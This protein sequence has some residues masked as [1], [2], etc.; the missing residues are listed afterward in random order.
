MTV[1]HQQYH[2]QNLLTMPAPVPPPT[3]HP[4]FTA[5]QPAHTG[6]GTFDGTHTS[7]YRQPFYQNSPYD[8]VD[9]HQGYA[10]MQPPHPPAV[11]PPPYQH[12]PYYQHHQGYGQRMIP[13]EAYNAHTTNS[14]F[15]PHHVNTQPLSNTPSRTSG[16]TTM[17]TSTP[18]RT[19]RP[20]PLDT[21]NSSTP[22]SR[23]TAGTSHDWMT[24]QRPT[25]PTR[26]ILDLDGVATSSAR[27]VERQAS[28]VSDNG[29]DI[30][31]GLP[32]YSSSSCEFL[33]L[34]SFFVLLLN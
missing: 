33:Y 1:Q 20:T 8:T 29:D 22:T 25:S 34:N 27:D 13:Y 18:S 32:S 15:T 21:S 5:G 16:P 26:N 12:N 3:I 30:D 24:Q 2:D 28:E 9:P 7:T 11:F 23:S 6:H 14:T 19:S 17:D 4:P 10:N 31:D